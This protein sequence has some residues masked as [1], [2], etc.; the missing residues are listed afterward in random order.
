MEIIVADDPETAA[1]EVAR[2]LATVAAAGGS[3]A[4]AGG[5][6]P[7]RAYELAVELEPDWSRVDVWLGDE[8]CVAPDDA[9]SNLRLV[10]DVLVARTSNV[11]VVH[12]VRTELPPVEAAARYHEELVGVVLDVALLGLGSDGHTASLFPHAP[13]LD[14]TERLAVAAEPGLEPWVDRVTMTIPAFAAAPEVVLLAVG[15]DKA[16]AARRAFADPPSRATP[17]SLVRSGTGRTVAVLDRA[18]AAELRGSG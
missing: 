7:R 3:V 6:T 10:M 5:S 12:A 8:R 2:R 15:P 9:R 16:E 4:L 14:E 13:A 17:A 1:R 18:A 11:P